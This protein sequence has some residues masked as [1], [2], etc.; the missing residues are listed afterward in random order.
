MT[1]VVLTRVFP[2]LA[3]VCTTGEI[4]VLLSPSA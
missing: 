2:A 1:A 3:Q 4:L